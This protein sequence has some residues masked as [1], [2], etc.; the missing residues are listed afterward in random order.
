MNPSLRQ[1][2]A[3]VPPPANPV[4][5]GLPN[6]WKQVE[7]EL[8]TFLPQDF[9]D[10]VKIYGAGQWT[11]FFGVW[12]PF[13]KWKNPNASKTWKAW[14][15]KRFEGFKEFQQQYPDDTAPFAVHPASG[16]LLAF[17]FND[18]GG[19]LCWRTIGSPDSWSIVCLDAELSNRY[20]EFELTLTAFI[21][22]LME[23]R[24]SPKTFPPDFF[25]IRQPAFQPYT[26]E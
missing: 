5:L 3:L 10:Y 23:K 20:D 19:T 14:R 16:G 8:G 26:T 13:Y 4:A 1:L 21:E 9:K 12:N 11:G 15:E 22:A 25:P 18:N 17:G 6:D 24:I 2:I 7:D